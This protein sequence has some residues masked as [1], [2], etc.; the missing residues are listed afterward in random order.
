[1]ADAIMALTANIA[2]R[3]RKRVDFQDE[4]F[5]PANSRHPGRR[6]PLAH[7][8][9]VI[10][11]RMIRAGSVSDGLERT[12][13]YASG[14]EGPSLTLPARKDRRLRF[15]LGRTVAYAS[16]SEGPSLTLPARKDHRSRLPAPAVPPGE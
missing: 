12:V 15:R 16:G 13:A 2:M 1:M 11:R 10:F 8:D 3:D 7:P 4:W 9:R 6:P 14:S 5:D